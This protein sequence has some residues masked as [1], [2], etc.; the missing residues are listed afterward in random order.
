MID[1]FD[2][3]HQFLS[4]FHPA[5]VQLDGVAYPSVEHAYQAAKTYDPEWRERVRIAA[6][7]G[8]AKRLGAKLPVRE[9]WNQSKLGVMEHLLRQKFE[10]PHLLA[11]LHATIG[12]DLVE[13]NT[14]G[15]R[16]WGVHDD[17]G[18]NHLGRLLM[19]IR[20]ERAPKEENVGAAMSDFFSIYSSIGRRG[21]FLTEAALSVDVSR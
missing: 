2:G 6:T 4:N 15:D 20:D 1:R 9:D 16:F 3:E 21:S 18:H 11:A 7:P 14:W 17:E 13:R 8:K 5:P 10:H 12:H 19:K